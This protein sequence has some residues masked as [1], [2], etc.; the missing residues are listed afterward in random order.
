MI[1]APAAWPAGAGAAAGGAGFSLRKETR[2]KAAPTGT[3]APASNR[4]NRKPS[5]GAAAS[6]VALAVWS[7]ATGSPFLTA[8]P[9]GTSHWTSCTVSSLTPSRGARIGAQ[10]SA[11]RINR[12]SQNLKDSLDHGIHRRQ[13]VIF[14]VPHRRDRHG[15]GADRPTGEAA[16]QLLRDAGDH[17]RRHAE[18]RFDFFDDHQ[19]PRAPHRL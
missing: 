19:T 17:G 14:E 18:D 3:S 4:W 5:P 12:L 2:P 6:S 8:V 11:G 15:P 9:S 10:V 1:G 16:R 13:H 7:S